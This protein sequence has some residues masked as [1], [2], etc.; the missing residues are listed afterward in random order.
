[1]GIL[2]HNVEGNS[3]TMGSV[4]STNLSLYTLLLGELLKSTK[5]LQPS[6]KRDLHGKFFW[7]PYLISCLTLLPSSCTSPYLSK[8]IRTT[9]EKWKVGP[10]LTRGP[11]KSVEVT[12]DL[13]GTERTEHHHYTFRYYTSLPTS[14]LFSCVFLARWGR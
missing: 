3:S 11:Y 5:S 10:V 2:R 12:R 13:P 4:L 6:L 7:Q 9:I 1:M 8:R 14:S